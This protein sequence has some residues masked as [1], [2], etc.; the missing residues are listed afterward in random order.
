MTS[1]AL[2]ERLRLSQI[3]DVTPRQEACS[4]A[5]PGLFGVTDILKYAWYDN[6]VY[7]YH[8]SFTG[9]KS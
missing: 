2:W 4:R 5:A 6:L 9:S 8:R 3:R 7:K 1:P